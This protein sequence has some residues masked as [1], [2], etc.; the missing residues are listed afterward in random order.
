M[1]DKAILIREFVP[2]PECVSALNRLSEADL[3]RL[4]QIARLRSLGLSD[5]DWRDLLQEAVTR[6]LDGSRRWPRNIS[7]VV[8]LRETMRSIVSDYWRRRRSSVI[9]LE[10]DLLR[11]EDA[12]HSDIIG[13]AQDPT[14][15]PEREAAAA[16]TLARVTEIFQDD[17]EARTVIAGMAYGKSPKEIQEEASMTPR[18]YATTQRRIRRNLHRA[19]PDR[20]ALI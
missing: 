7:L 14:R 13:N 9:L 10:S 15:N 2:A 3:R 19:F 6:L 12:E 8:F 5:L 17:C 20:E 11:A 1:E 16:E 4:E 18:Q